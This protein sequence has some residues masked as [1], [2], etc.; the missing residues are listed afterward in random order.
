MSQIYK[1]LTSGPVPPAVPT[2]FVTDSGTAVPALNV[3]NVLTPG[4][5]TQGIMTSG[6]GNTITITVTDTGLVGTATTV[7]AISANLIVFTMPAVPA[8]V[9]FDA[10]V[11]ALAT[12]GAGIPL[13][14]AYT[15]VGGAR[16][17]GATATL[18]PFQELD[19][20]EDTAL[21]TA[22]AQ[23]TVSGNTVILGVTG[24]AAYTIDWSGEMGFT[25]A[26]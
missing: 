8:T 10:R 25:R 9:V 4:G 20:F 3:L 13:G 18:L 11:A 12:V 14:V 21:T 2:S 15:L 5:G 22:H 24:V 16:T 6:A 23:L 26:S 7:G 1:S 17:D 19:E